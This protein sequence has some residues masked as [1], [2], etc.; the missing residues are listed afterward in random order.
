MVRHELIAI[1]V[2][3]LLDDVALERVKA[4]NRRMLASVPSGFAFDDRHTPH[5]TLLQRYVPVGALGDV[6]AAVGEVVAATPSSS[7]EL[8]AHG[9]VHERH[10][11]LPGVGVAVVSVT[12][13]QVII[14]LHHALIGATAPWAR[15]GG[16]ASTFARSERDPEIDPPTI[17]YVERFVPDHSDANYAPHVTVGMALLDDLVAIEAEPFES[18]SVR[19]SSFAVYHLG[20]NG[21]AQIRLHEWP[22]V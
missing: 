6:V 19:P 10:P 7:I 20:N 21:T 9:V 8:T 11:S 12:S 3:V 22:W 17:D 14:D 16:D 5:V 1:D 18:F 13:D 15:A 2:L 4:L